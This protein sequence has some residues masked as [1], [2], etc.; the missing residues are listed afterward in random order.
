MKKVILK[1]V[2]FLTG[3]KVHATHKAIKGNKSG[4]T[5]DSSGYKHWRK[6]SGTPYDDVN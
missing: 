2:E 5:S 6:G 3:A 1:T 4:G